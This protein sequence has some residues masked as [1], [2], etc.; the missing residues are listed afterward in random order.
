MT[1]NNPHLRQAKSLALLSAQHAQ[2]QPIPPLRLRLG[3][4]EPQTG[5]S[6]AA[7]MAYEHDTSYYL[8]EE[9]QEVAANCLSTFSEDSEEDWENSKSNKD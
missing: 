7:Y 4:T 8:Q 3:H 5:Q 2:P 1:S 6:Q 9:D